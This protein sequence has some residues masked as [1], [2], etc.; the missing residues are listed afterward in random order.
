[1]NHGI[2]GRIAGPP[3][4]P[5]PPDGLSEDAGR[6]WRETLA[7][8]CFA[9]S[10]LALVE[11]A[12]RSLDRAEAARALVEAEGLC[13][14][15]ESSGAVRAHPAIRIENEARREF[16]LTWRVLGLVDPSG[17]QEASR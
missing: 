11:S 14:T 10:E 15:T 1:M 13:T 3:D 9:P 8:Y 4:I 12:L 7:R 17:L 16:R 2:A 6:L 5:P